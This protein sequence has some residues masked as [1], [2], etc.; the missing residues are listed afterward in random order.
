MAVANGAEGPR[1]LRDARV[2]LGVVTAI[3]RD[4]QRI[5]ITVFPMD[6][7]DRLAELADGG[8]HINAV[9]K[10]VAGIEVAAERGTRCIPQAQHRLHIVHQHPRVHLDPDFHPVRRANSATPLQ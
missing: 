1:P 6:M 3:H 7:D 9:P 8:Y 4:V 2:G 10:Q 5:D